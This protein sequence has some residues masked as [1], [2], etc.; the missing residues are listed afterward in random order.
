M[1][2][3]Q[4]PPAGPE[5]RG[6]LSEDDYA[7][8]MTTSRRPKKSEDAVVLRSLLVH[9]LRDTFKAVFRLGRKHGRPAMF[10]EYCGRWT[11]LQGPPPHEWRCLFCGHRYAIEYAVYGEVE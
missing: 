2:T 3:P 10:C 7:L 1:G 11:S 5:R 6:S 8:S 9:R 4:P